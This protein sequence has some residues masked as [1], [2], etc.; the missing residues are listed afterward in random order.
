MK[1][2]T[3][4]VEITARKPLGGPGSFGFVGGLMNPGAIPSND[5]V[6]LLAK[7]NACHWKDAT[8]LAADLYMKGSPMLLQTDSNLEVQESAC[9][10]DVFGFEKA[11]ETAIEDFRL[12][13]YRDKL[14]VNA[15]M[16]VNQIRRG[17]PGY[18]VARQW[19]GELDVA[20]KSITC[21]GFP[22]LDFSTSP[23]EKNW[24]YFELGGDVYMLYSISPYHLLKCS[25]WSGLRF[26]TLIREDISANLASVIPLNGRISISTNPTPYDETHLLVLLH[27][28]AKKFQGFRRRRVYYHWAMLLDKETLRPIKISSRPVFVG[29]NAQ[30]IRPGI[31]YVMAAF[32][33]N[34]HVIFSLGESDSHSS[35]IRIPKT[36]LDEYWVNL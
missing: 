33:Q 9:I 15:V 20:G 12:F 32:R 8:G 24:G 6:T 1:N 25:D 35:I 10:V 18:D 2:L 11:A 13:H 34:D 30:G 28:H 22:K 17:K 19:C 27:T 3:A 7:A 36:V 16:T 4:I 14:W 31:V 23:I 26:E 5:G 29:G 21:N